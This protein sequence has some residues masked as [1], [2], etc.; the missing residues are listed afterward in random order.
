MI[1][2][3]K[4]RFEPRTYNGKDYVQVLLEDFGIT[5]AE[6]IKI[7][8]YLKPQTFHIDDMPSYHQKG[9]VVF[10]RDVEGVKA[11]IKLKIEMGNNGEELVVISFHRDR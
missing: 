5:P 8:Q 2:N 4:Y 11:Y 9:S 6:A 7:I 10:K 1:Y 3:N